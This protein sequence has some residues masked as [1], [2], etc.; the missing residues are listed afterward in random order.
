MNLGFFVR[1]L[2]SVVVAALAIGNIG[3]VGAQQTSVTTELLAHDVDWGGSWELED[4]TSEASAGMESVQLQS[5]DHTAF[6]VAIFSDQQLPRVEAREAVLSS[7]KEADAD[8]TVID[9]G[10]YGNLSYELTAF[11]AGDQRFG[12]FTLVFTEPTGTVIYQIAAPQADFAAAVEHAQTQITVDA[13]PIF[14]GID[15]GSLAVQIGAAESVA[16][17]PTNSG[18]DTGTGSVNSSET[19]SQTS[20]QTASSSSTGSHTVAGWNY[21]VNYPTTWTPAGDI[22]DFSL[23]YGPP[24]AMIGFMAIENPG[25][26]GSTL[27]IV[28]L[29]TFKETLGPGGTFVTSGSDASRAVFVGVSGEGLGLI[30][31]III[32]SPSTLIIVTMVVIDDTEAAVANAKQI[33]INGIRILSLI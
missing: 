2:C 4:H 29:D 25:V 27:E 22:G 15:G 24:S 14:V 3:A 13:N 5:D 16:N 6:F 10:D 30:Q 11:D 26:D 1:I 20:N 7:I 17:I 19:N 28:L 18:S 33:D 8:V 32:V 31:E 21:T 9:A 23:S 12:A